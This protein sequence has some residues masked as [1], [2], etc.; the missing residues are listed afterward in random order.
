MLRLNAPPRRG[1]QAFS[2]KGSPMRRVLVF[3]LAS[4]ICLRLS[5]SEPSAAD[6]RPRIISLYAAHTEMLLR[7]GAHDNIIGVSRQENYSGPETEGWRPETF[8]IRDDVERFIAAKP[9]L[10]LARPQHLADNARLRQALENAGIQI[11]ALQVTKAAD[12]YVYWR[13]LAKYVHREEN[14]EKLIAD[15]DAAIERYRLAAERFEPK[16]GIFIESIHKEI[17]TFTPDSLPYWL[18]DLAGGRNVAD[19]AP[20]VSPGVIIAAYGPERLLSKARDIDIFISQ[21][22]TMNNIPL[23]TLQA[24]KL[25]QPL[26]AFKQNK[27]YIIPEALLARP[28][29]SILQGLAQLAEWTGLAAAMN[30]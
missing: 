20:A 26:Q 21:N 15:F 12:L 16:P 24:R 6:S 18:A 1:V 23:A 9:D 13:T 29:P 28:T 27:V 3:F 17:K 19:D 7:L 11:Q 22:G 14:A 25:Y 2:D 10:I 8:S 4:L 5:A 30:E